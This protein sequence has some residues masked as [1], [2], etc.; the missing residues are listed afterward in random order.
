MKNVEKW[1]KIG[2]MSY[3]YPFKNSLGAINSIALQKHRHPVLVPARSLEFLKP[4]Y[5]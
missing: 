3:V 4:A 5:P 2:N 1:V